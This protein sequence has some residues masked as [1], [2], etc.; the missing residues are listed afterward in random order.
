MTQ[1]K[2]IEVFVDNDGE[3]V[4]QGYYTFRHDMTD[5][6]VKAALSTKLRRHVD[7]IKI[8]SSSLVQVS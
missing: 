5:K 6:A 1:Y 4:P 7:N 3:L 2:Q 8:G